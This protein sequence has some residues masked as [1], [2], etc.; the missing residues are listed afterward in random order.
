LLQFCENHPMVLQHDPFQTWSPLICTAYP[1]YFLNFFF[2][3]CFFINILVP[4]KSLPSY[5]TWHIHKA[6]V[7]VAQKLYT[8][9]RKVTPIYCNF[10][11]TWY[12]FSYRK[13]FIKLSCVLR[14]VN[15]TFTATDIPTLTG[16]I[17]VVITIRPWCDRKLQ[18][19]LH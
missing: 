2:F 8:H 7:H 15:I 5:I 4:H 19:S 13:M 3:I 18:C 11:N 14:S 17:P 6:S 10:R 1:K 12:A 9:Q 16:R